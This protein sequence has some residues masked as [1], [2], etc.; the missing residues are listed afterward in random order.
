MLRI[1]ALSARPEPTSLPVERNEHT[2]G[3]TPLATIL[4]L[5][6]KVAVD[7][8]LTRLV[9]EDM[10]ARSDPPNKR[11][12]ARTT[13]IAGTATRRTVRRGRARQP[14][15]RSRASMDHGSVPMT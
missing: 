12:A 3:Q 7:S 8:D 14:T 2:L 5:S 1:V 6:N 15:R 13:K 11:D 10:G 4:R 9:L